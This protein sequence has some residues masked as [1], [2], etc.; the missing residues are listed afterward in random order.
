MRSR[1]GKILRFWKNL[2]QNVRFFG[3]R[4]IFQKS[5]FSPPEIGLP[6]RMRLGWSRNDISSMA[7]HF[8]PWRDPNLS[9]RDCFLEKSYVFQKILRGGVRFFGRR[10]IFGNHPP[11]AQQWVAPYRKVLRYGGNCIPGPSQPH[12]LRVAYSSRLAQDFQK[13]LRPPK[14][15]TL[16]RKIFSAA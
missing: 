6:R 13:I 11:Q 12:P 1:F 14:N 4:K 5:R 2:T 10:K 16:R 8:S 15:L 9:R 7:Q 3:K